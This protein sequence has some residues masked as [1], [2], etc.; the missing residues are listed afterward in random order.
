MRTPQTVIARRRSLFLRVH[1]WAALIASPFAILAAL[2][3]LL[4]V[5]TPQV[6]A[7]L[8][9][10]LDR[11]AVVGHARPLDEVVRAAQA[12]AP[13]G[14]H[15]K[16]VIV[17]GRADASV[18]VVFSPARHALGDHAGHGAPAAAPAP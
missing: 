16:N 1:F 5:F 8:H 12:V 17:P 4:Y 15:L 18:Q 10:D 7:V 14:Q 9:G 2:T 11:V 3:G 6:E 13:A